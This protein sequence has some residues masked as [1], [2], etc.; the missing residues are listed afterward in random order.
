MNSGKKRI[1]CFAPLFDQ[2]SK[3]LVLGTMPGNESLYQGMYYANTKNLFWDFMYRILVPDYPPYQLLDKDTPKQA[4]YELLKANHIALWDI[5]ADCFRSD[6]RDS[7]I[8]D[9]RFNDI[10]GFVKSTN[11]KAVIC[12]GAKS[13]EYLEIAGQKP[14]IAIPVHILGSTSTS[15]QTNPFK[16]FGQWRDTFN[17]LS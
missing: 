13:N 14:Q 7:K 15:N 11:I 6:N 1:T 8:I 12:N 10:A 16:T 4:R 2:H 17:A 5:V 9:P 3:I